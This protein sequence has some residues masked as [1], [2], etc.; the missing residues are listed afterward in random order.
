MVTFYHF[1]PLCTSQTTYQGGGESPKCLSARIV[2]AVWWM[3]CFF[4]LLIYTANL[5]AF[6]TESKMKTPV[7][8]I[9]D[10]A[11]DMYLDLHMDQLEDLAK[12]VVSF[13]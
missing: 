2:A 3:C 8:K 1:S 4:I 5:S 7:E 13:C 9:E 11:S 12:V 10:L 6:L